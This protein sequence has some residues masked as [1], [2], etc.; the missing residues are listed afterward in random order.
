MVDFLLR[1]LWETWS[2]LEEAS[3]F[4]LL[5][6]AL[7]G[8]LRVLVPRTKLIQLVGRG[9]VRSVLWG[10]AIGAPLP[11]C[12]CGVLPTALG[13]LRQGATPGAT[14]AFLIATPETGADSIG[15]SYAL[16]DPIMTLFRPFAGVVT[17][18]AAGLATNF[19]GVRPRSGS[20]MSP[21]LLSNSSD[22]SR[23]GDHAHHGPTEHDHLCSDLFHTERPSV[24]NAVNGLAT[25]AHK[26]NRIFHY[27]F[28][29]LLDE[30]SHW[31][32]LGFLLSG[33]MAAIL[34]SD[35][36]ER[37]LA[38]GVTSML[39]MLFISM[40]IYTCASSSTPL[41]AAMVMKGLNPGAALVF[42]LAGPATNL[43]NL[44]VLLRFLGP[45][46]VVTYLATTATLALLAGYALNGLYRALAVDPRASF[47]SA[48]EYLPQDVKLAGGIVL[49]ALLVH[50]VWRTPAPAE[51]LWKKI[52]DF[53]GIENWIPAVEKC[54]L[55]KGGKE[56]TV[57]VKGDGQVVERL[58]N[59]DDAKRTYS[60]TILSSGLP[61]DDYHST[62]SVEPDGNGSV[63]KWRGTY[64]AKGTSDAEAKKLIDGIYADASKT[65]L[66][67]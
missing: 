6:F 9:R 22:Q 15:L 39:A 43:G 40:P 61:V 16:T 38:G 65:L 67:E 56:R 2:I 45:R 11:L 41:A 32:V 53:C 27:G 42:L 57:Y 55:S 46:I 35:F 49:V 33:I 59:W 28:R 37:Y 62:I 52:G 48:S 13:A 24:H 36:F 7:A 14:V 44:V 25:I 18:V 63:L 64:K 31:L 30:T 66:G 58:D 1:V 51:W 5:G 17:A 54:V 8:A 23:H 19:L 47:G 34:P 12:S 10:S 20:G 4:L 26:A 29:E 60:Y 21:D 3:I 50:S